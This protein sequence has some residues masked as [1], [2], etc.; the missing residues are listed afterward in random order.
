MVKHE[1]APWSLQLV[2]LDLAVPKQLSKAPFP[3]AARLA[4][5]FD[6]NN[7]SM[8]TTNLHEYHSIHAFT[9]AV[10]H[11]FLIF[12][13]TKK[14][15]GFYLQLYLYDLLPH[16]AA[17]FYGLRSWSIYRAARRRYEHGEGTGMQLTDLSR[18]S[19][20]SGLSRNQCISIFNFF[21]TSS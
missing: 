5:M 13:I 2:W 15:H 3:L 11:P 16:Q 9:A 18:Y 17:F 10:L 1:R 14:L 8:N 12:A 19:T 7:P 6:K 21:T 4:A 20:A